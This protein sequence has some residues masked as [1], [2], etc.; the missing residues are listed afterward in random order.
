MSEYNAPHTVIFQ[1]DKLSLLDNS[2]EKKK[3][4]KEKLFW[5]NR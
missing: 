4:A 2:K 3:V 1:I 5:N